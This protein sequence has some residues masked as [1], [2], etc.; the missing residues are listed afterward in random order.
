MLIISQVH[1]SVKQ[2]FIHVYFSMIWLV[3][4]KAFLAILPE[5]NFVN[6]L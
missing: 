5:N 3:V 6:L 4:R 1:I 2:M